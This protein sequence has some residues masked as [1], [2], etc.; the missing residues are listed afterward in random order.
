MPQARKGAP[1]AP[2]P[3]SANP[4]RHL[5]LPRSPPE[6]PSRS[7]R[8][9]SPIGNFAFH[10]RARRD[11]GLGL[12]RKLRQSRR[13]ELGPVR[14]IA[15][16]DQRLLGFQQLLTR[17]GK[18]LLRCCQFLANRREA[19]LQGAQLLNSA[20]KRPLLGERRLDTGT[21]ATELV[22][23]GAELVPQHGERALRIIDRLPVPFQG[24]DRRFK[25]RPARVECATTPA[26]ASRRPR[27]AS[28]AAVSRP[29]S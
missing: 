20:R 27:T 14:L 9:P 4:A 25:V 24:R 11:Q 12:R 1:Y 8:R 23:L 2:P 10:S 15:R 16:L 28:R 17:G 29:T 3:P 26:S 18:R 22:P 19:R 7:A 5:R 13:Q 6:A 21:Y